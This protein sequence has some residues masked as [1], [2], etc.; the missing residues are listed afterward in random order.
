MNK[1]TYSEKLRDPRW[2]KKRLEIFNRDDF[3]CLSCGSKE[4]TL[5]VHHGI[6]KKGCEPWEYENDSLHTLCEDCHGFREAMEDLIKS[7]LSKLPGH[8]I[9]MFLE[10]LANILK[11]TEDSHKHHELIGL[12]EEVE[13]KGFSYIKKY[14]ELEVNQ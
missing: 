1:K 4:K 13:S 2:Q 10:M 3:K 5:H 9:C 6:Y 8:A 12:I 7:T 11:K 14:K